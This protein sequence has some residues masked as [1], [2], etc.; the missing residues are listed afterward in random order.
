MMK[1]ALNFQVVEKDL[2]ELGQAGVRGTGK[3][4]RERVFRILKKEKAEG[5]LSITFCDDKLMKKLNKKYRNKDKTT[6]VLSFEF[7][8]KE[9]VMGDIYISVPQAVKQAKE[10]GVTL[11]E[12]LERLAIHGTLH[13]LGYTHK[14]MGRYVG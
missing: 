7:G 4:I 2:S 1:I 11:K 5:E 13:V 9:R 8:D 12:E 10:Y 14:E 3:G 6:D